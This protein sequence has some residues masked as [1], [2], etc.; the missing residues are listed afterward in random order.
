MTILITGALG[1]IGSELTTALR[2][3]Y[4]HDQVI[5][6]DILNNVASEY[7]PY[8]N[9]EWKSNFPRQNSLQN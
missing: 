3:I 4:G 7:A 5:A 6:S 2:N 8:E 9:Q 1:Q